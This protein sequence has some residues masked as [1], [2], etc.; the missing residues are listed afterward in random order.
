MALT[1]AGDGSLPSLRLP[2]S[3]ARAEFTESVWVSHSTVTVFSPA[4]GCAV[5]LPGPRPRASAPSIRDERAVRD[6]SFMSVLSRGARPMV[7]GAD[8]LTL[9]LGAARPPQQRVA[10]R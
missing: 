6:R 2:P 4:I 9:G 10:G 8:P 5:A 3:A 7:T 1:C